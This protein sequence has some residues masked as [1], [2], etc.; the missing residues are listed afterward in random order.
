MLVGFSGTGNYW[1]SGK[2]I[3]RIGIQP[4][5]IVR[6][7]I[8]DYKEDRDGVLEKAIDFLSKKK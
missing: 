5:I 8:Q 2:E 1:L 7:S 4:K 3:Q 6:P